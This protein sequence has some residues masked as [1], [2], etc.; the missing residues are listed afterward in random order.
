MK[1]QNEQGHPEAFREMISWS[2]VWVS[3]INEPAM[4]TTSYYIVNTPAYYFTALCSD[5]DRNAKAGFIHPILGECSRDLNITPPHSSWSDYPRF[6]VRS[7]EEVTTGRWINIMIEL[8]F[9]VTIFVGEIQQVMAFAN[10]LCTVCNFPRGACICGT[11]HNPPNKLW[12]FV[13]NDDCDIT[14]TR[15]L[16]QILS[17]R[18]CQIHL[19]LEFDEEVK[20]QTKKT[21][22]DLLSEPEVFEPL[23]K[24]LEDTGALIYGFKRSRTISDV[25][26]AAGTFIRS[27]TGRSNLYFVKDLMSMIKDE[28]QEFLLLQSKGHWTDTLSDIYENYGKCKNTKLANRLK[29]VFN[30]LI[31]HCVYHKLG[32]EVDPVQFAI[33]E[34]TVIRPNLINYLTFI[35]AVIGLLTYVLKAGRQCMV[36]GSIEPLFLDESSV[37]EWLA[38]TKQIKV[39]SEFLGNPAAIGM[40]VHSFLARLEKVIIDSRSIT[41]FLAMGSI[42]YRLV[43]SSAM[44]MDAIQKRYL[45]VTAAQSVRK[46]PLAVVLYG[47]PGVGK[48]SVS[49][50]LTNYDALRRGRETGEGFVFHHESSDPYMTGFRSSMHTMI[51]DDVAQHAP[52]KIQGIDPGSSLVL[53]VINNQPLTPNQASLED[54]GK[55]PVLV[56]LV[57]VTTNCKDMNLPVYYPASYAP[58]RRLRWNIEVLVKEKYRKDGGSDIDP[59]KANSFETYPDYWIFVIS[60]AVP[61]SVGSQQGKYVEKYMFHEITKF[62]Q[63]FG[64][65]SDIHHKNQTEWLANANLYSKEK[66]C[67]C[68]MPISL[69]ECSQISVQGMKT[70]LDGTRY[71]C[72]D[73]DTPLY[74]EV[75][76]EISS[77]SSE[78]SDDLDIFQEPQE[79]LPRWRPVMHT[80]IPRDYHFILSYKFQKR[81]Q[82][83]AKYAGFVQ[84]FAQGELPLLMR[85]GWTN[86]QIHEDFKE[87]MKFK[88]EESEIDEMCIMSGILFQEVTGREEISTWCD[89]ILTHLINFYF[90]WS[91]VRKT[92]KYFGKYALVRRTF[93]TWMRPSLVKTK[94]QKY[95]MSKVGAK[96][97]EKLEGMNRW[98]KLGLAA[99]STV[100]I[101]GI[102]AKIWSQ[103]SLG[104]TP[105]T[106][107]SEIND[108][109]STRASFISDESSSES[110]DSSYLQ[111]EKLR[112]VGKYPE[113]DL[114]S[115][116]TNYWSQTERTV[117]TV[118]FL[119]GRAMDETSF[120]KKLLRNVLRFETWSKD[121]GGTFKNQGHLLV[122]SN[123]CFLTNNHSLPLGHDL[124]MTFHFDKSSGVKPSVSSLI[125]QSQIMRIPDRDIAIVTTKSLPALFKDISLNFVKESF[126]GIYD[127]YYLVKNDDGTTD[128]IVVNRIRKAHYK[129]EINGIFFDLEVF[130][131]TAERE[132]E[133][134]H[135]GAPLIMLTGH[136]PVVV[137]FHAILSGDRVIA[138]KFSYED[139]REFST[140][141]KIQSGSIPV[142]PELLYQAPTSYIDFHQEG[143]IIYHGELKGFRS[144]PKHHVFKTELS[145]Q[146][147]GKKILDYTIE[148]RLTGPVMDSWRPQ[149]VALAQFIEPVAFM[150]ES[151]LELCKKIFKQKVLS[152]LPVGELLKI[153]PV[154]IDV[155]VNGMVGV[156]YMDAIKLSTSMGFPYKTTKRKYVFPLDDSRWPNGVRFTQEIEDEILVWYN[157]MESGE[158]CHGVFSANLKDEPVSWK[159][160][161]MCKTRVFF[162]G[163]VVLLVI[164]RMMFMGFCRVVQ[165]NNYIFMCAVGMNCHS[166]EWDELFKFLSRFGVNTAIAGDYAFFDKK[167][168]M[169]LVR[170]AMEFIIE[171]CEESGNFSESHLLVMRCIMYDLMNPTVDYFGMLITLLGGEVSG[172]QLTTIFNCIMNIF[173]QMYMYG[174]AGYDVNEFFLYIVSIAL[175]DDHIICVSPER[176]LYTH[177]FIK[178]KMLELGVDYTMADKE[179][180]S[181]PYINL[182]EASFLKRKFRYD[183]ELGVHL[184][185]IDKETLG[186]M[187][188]IQV[189]SKSCSKSEQLA[190]AITSA[191]MESFLHGKE[192]FEA[193]HVLLDSLE[194]SLSLKV[195]MEEFKC[196]SWEENLARFWKTDKRATVFGEGRNQNLP[197]DDSNCLDLNGVLQSR[198]RMDHRMDPAR[199]IPEAGFHQSARQ[200]THKNT[201]DRWNESSTC[202][203]NCRLSKTTEQTNNIQSDVPETEGSVQSEVQQTTFYGETVPETLDLSVP[204]DPTTRSQLTDYQLD[205]YLSRP[206]KI[207]EVTW[208]ENGPAGLLSSFTPA[209]LYFNLPIIKNKLEGYRYAKFDLCLKFTINGSPFYYG[210]LGAFLTP[211]SGYISDTTGAS[212]GYAPGTQVLTSQKQHV[213]LD[214]QTTSVSH[215]KI[216]FLYNQNWMDMSQLTNLIKFSKVDLVQFAA[217][218]SANGVSTT[219]I[220]IVVYAW[221]ENV[222]LTG[223]TSRTVLQAKKEYAHD[224]QISGP[225][226]TVAKMANMMSKV[227][228]IGPFA[229]A[230]D[231]V[232][233]AL[234][235]AASYF[236]YT[237]V[238][239]ISD[240]EPFKSVPFHTLASS[241]ISEPINKLSLQPKQEI[242]VSGFT[243]GDPFADPLHIANFCGRESFLCGAL[244]T[245]TDAADKIV[246]TSAVTP[247]LY[248]S[249][250]ITLFQT[251]MT[252]M[253]YMFNLF[254]YWRGDIIFRFKIVKSQYHRGRLNIC[255]DVGVTTASQ[256][257]TFGNPSVMNIVFDI[258]ETD[259]IEVRVPYM[260]A[261]PFLK[262]ENQTVMGNLNNFWSN[263]STPTFSAPNTSNGT[264]QVRVINRLT[265]PEASSDVDLLVFVR[266]ADNIEFAGPVNLKQNYTHLQVQSKKIYEEVTFGKD[267]IS[268][269]RTYDSHFGERI[270]SARELLHRQSK[271]GTWGIP[272]TSSYWTNSQMIVKFP[273]QRMPRIYGFSA[274]GMHFAPG[275]I[276]PA[277]LFGFNYVPNHP[278]VYLTQ[279]FVGYK[280]S[281]NFNF[282]AMQFQGEAQVNVPSLSVTR[283]DTVLT[284]ATPSAFCPNPIST[285]QYAKDWT[286]TE[287]ELQAGAGTALTNQNTQ[288]GLAVNLPFY[289]RYKFFVTNAIS[290]NSISN[291]TTLDEANLDWYILALK[292]GITSATLDQDTTVEVYCGT[293]PDFDL[294][295]FMNCPV[296]YYLP[297][298]PARQTF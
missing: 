189:E 81:Y 108:Y 208:T 150:K 18:K 172:H 68:L 182:Y 24:V 10:S 120:N 146:L 8:E 159:K 45:S 53:K 194:K 15:Q 188:T 252:P 286:G 63:W 295:Y 83:E 246:F 2:G 187:L 70:R 100:T 294:V 235:A 130:T 251:F 245:T 125:E 85:K 178:E 95:F 156:D 47:T 275:V 176:P 226:S 160:Y 152:E 260:Q 96:I 183:V 43:Q 72:P 17:R 121:E 209:S 274:S 266:A 123:E 30:H 50:M 19:V 217:L 158:R 200:D 56:D 227:P 283:V 284:T 78:Y 92:A 23:V 145:S 164:V 296:L 46:Q 255:W 190:Q 139:F 129:R 221:A 191:S 62:L 195:H 193:F 170:Y 148:D 89:V 48:T 6:V 140:E 192:F 128:K 201:K 59:L 110:D 276:A 225:A 153:H 207:V 97:D 234:G 137:G 1:A 7:E 293:G 16:N 69:C 241:T 73:S 27:L 282:N 44:E 206:A 87:F 212:L 261:L 171:I 215:M 35:D 219:G 277:N 20:L 93:I 262:K 38:R 185:P 51:M 88:I 162:S 66:I 181:Q 109:E 149:Q 279:C 272:Q 238:P 271:V 155:A 138:S 76:S 236:G 131:G 280:G 22:E 112:A 99:I 168:K 79:P 249:N 232:A 268:E 55:T 184:G 253:C 105:Q 230:T 113:R 198:R 259:E 151:R 257:P 154:P 75:S 240:V 216:P 13:D 163:P 204:H 141:M 210:S 90:S 199:A 287:G 77:S 161:E 122:L 297:P 270:S 106:E 142:E 33:M 290:Q 169:V 243:S 74:N 247:E 94:N 267:T 229:K 177:T 273:F 278:L 157:R 14:T 127:G 126:D 5:L 136:G 29:K 86:K 239:N 165:R 102:I 118:D 67:E 25:L 205:S 28:L 288:S 57:I 103:F 58:M 26:I 101:I 143:K 117:T 64:E 237:N 166:M 80:G 264:I 104:K 11:N 21:Y 214:P 84:E 49:N 36:A 134:G 4:T 211:M 111:A 224:G 242:S 60:E 124:K 82:E 41:K 180:E 115:A 197:T 91:V 167:I 248:E 298:P 223:L 220:N 250:Q 132:T 31:A 263:G 12:R 269:I 71:Y 133:Y 32:I 98:V 292:R 65:Q 116:K 114:V 34:K 281:T 289:S 54:K 42:E 174:E 144:R 256:M 254:N 218:R 175:G 119:S 37:G 40:S 203:E 202:L 285:S 179:S 228:V 107:Q 186:K 213:W 222:E 196:F 61:V 258:E 9:V 265:A 147:F 3:A 39:D 231:T 291:L 135:C 233:S 244:W 173:Y 52:N